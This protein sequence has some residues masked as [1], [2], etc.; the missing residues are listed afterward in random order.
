[1]EKLDDDSWCASYLEEGFDAIAICMRQTGIDF[2]VI[3]KLR[4]SKVLVQEFR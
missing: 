2:G 1:M 4:T 3:E